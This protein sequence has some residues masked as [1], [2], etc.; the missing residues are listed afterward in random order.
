MT[1]AVAGTF[2]EESVEAADVRVQLRKGGKGES[3]LVLHSELGVPGWL[4]AYEELAG[5]FTVYVPS[6]PG[7]GQSTRPEMISRDSSIS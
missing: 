1:T 3:L 6:L 7:F 2:T 5:H 4:Q